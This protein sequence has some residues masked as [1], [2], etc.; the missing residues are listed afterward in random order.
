MPRVVDDGDRGN[1]DVAR[2]NLRE[3]RRPIQGRTDGDIL[4]DCHTP[5]P[6]SGCGMPQG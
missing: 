6:L 2:H 1:V 3:G 4:G 5:R